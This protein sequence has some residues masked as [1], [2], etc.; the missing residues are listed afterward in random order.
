MTWKAPCYLTFVIEN[1]GW[2]FYWR[3]HDIRHG[4]IRFFRR[5]DKVPSETRL[6]AD[7]WAF[8]NAEQFDLDGHSAFRCTNYVS[9]ERGPLTGR[10]TVDYCFQIYLEA[11]FAIG[12]R[13]ITMLIDP[14]GQNQG[15]GCGC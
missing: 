14:D 5:K 11:P 1:Q 4:P 7:N 2:K 6:Y 10:D 12:G 8:F 13:H 9:N 15:P 3:E